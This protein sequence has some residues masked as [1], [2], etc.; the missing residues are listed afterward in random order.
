MR[1]CDGAV[2]ALELFTAGAAD[3]GKGVAAAVEE[4]DGLLAAV[5]SLARLVDQGAGEELLLPGLLKLAAHV[6]EFDF[7]Q[8][9]VLDAVVH[10]DARVFALHG[11]LPAFER[12]RRRAKNHDCAGELGAHYGHVASVVAWCLLL[13]VALV[14]LFV[15]EDE[16][17]IRHR[18][19]D[20][21][22]RADNDGSLA[23][24]DAPP[25]L[26]AL[27]GCQRGV[28]EGDTSAKCGIEQSGHL[29]GQADLGNQE[30]GSLPAVESTLHGGEI[31]GGLS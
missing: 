16:A 17:K 27:L 21:R 5:E 26:G 11:V 1:E 15:D 18:R 3:D 14:V 7:R 2:L 19:K 8:R 13:L 10:L 24:M 22:S 25:L 29:R 28:Q 4:D 20:C 12:G 6:D 9:A 23:A 30:N 31:D